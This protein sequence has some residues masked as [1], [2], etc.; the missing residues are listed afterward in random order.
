MWCLGCTSLDIIIEQLVR[1]DAPTSSWVMTDDAPA[2]SGT[3]GA[4][5][6]TASADD[7]VLAGCGCDHCIAVQTPATTLAALQHPTPES[8]DDELGN[9]LSVDREP[10]VPPPIARTL[11]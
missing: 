1:G 6:V 4:P 10:L 7:S 2:R 5:S 11:A 9:A 3:D 8:V